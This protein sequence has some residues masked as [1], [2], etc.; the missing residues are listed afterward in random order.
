MSFVST[1]PKKFLL[2]FNGNLYLKHFYC[3]LFSGDYDKELLM[4]MKPK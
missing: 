4:T 1:T 3:E 2:S